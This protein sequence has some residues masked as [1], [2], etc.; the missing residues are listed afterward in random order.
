MP[1]LILGDTPQKEKL[2]FSHPLFVGTGDMLLR[3]LGVSEGLHG[4]A[5][6]LAG[7]I[8]SEP[9]DRFLKGDEKGEYK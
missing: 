8:S 1:G 2:F 3:Y 7:L 6:F 4:Y 9:G 5:S